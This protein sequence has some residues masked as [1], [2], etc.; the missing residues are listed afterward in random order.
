M[1]VYNSFERR[2]NQHFM[3]VDDTIVLL[4]LIAKLDEMLTYGIRDLSENQQVNKI[5]S[6]MGSC[7][8]NNKQAQLF[9]LLFFNLASRRS[10]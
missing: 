2:L 3:G 9:Y 1:Y 4:N 7:S 10:K 5:Q 6:I 8:I